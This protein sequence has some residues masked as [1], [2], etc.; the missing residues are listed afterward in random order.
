MGLV[1]LLF[2]DIGHAAS[3]PAG[4]R[5]LPAQGYIVGGAHLLNVHF[6]KRGGGGMLTVRYGQ[7]VPTLTVA[8]VRRHADLALAGKTGCILRKEWY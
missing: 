3:Q 1:H 2:D 5:G 7:G 6:V 8:G 4:E